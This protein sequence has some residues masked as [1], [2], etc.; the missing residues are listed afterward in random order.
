M[1]SCLLFKRDYDITD[2]GRVRWVH[3]DG[4]VSWVGWGWIGRLGDIGF[5]RVGKGRV[6]QRRA[7]H[8]RV[9]GGGVG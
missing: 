2:E 3:W 9:C 4:G 6:W 1:T 7:V 5:G 8:D